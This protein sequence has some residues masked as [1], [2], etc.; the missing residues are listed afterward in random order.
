MIYQFLFLYNTNL[1]RILMRY[2][3]MHDKIF[4]PIKPK[5]NDKDFDLR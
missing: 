2:K 1:Y 5:K 3:R 4:L